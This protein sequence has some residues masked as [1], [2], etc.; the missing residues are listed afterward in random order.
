MADWLMA[1]MASLGIEDSQVFLICLIAGFSILVVIVR[2][3]LQRLSD[4][5]QSEAEADGDAEAGDAEPFEAGDA[6]VAVPEQAWPV[7]HGG[8]QPASVGQ[9]F[10]R[11][12]AA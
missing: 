10:G 9:Q 4:E 5:A 12:R 3:Y 11:R 2:D 1:D 8:V 6:E 7:R